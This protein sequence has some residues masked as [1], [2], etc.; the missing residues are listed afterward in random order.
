MTMAYSFVVYTGNGV[1]QQYAVTFPFLERSHVAVTVNGVQSTAFTWVSDS[2]IR[3]NVA[4][5][6]GSTIR[7]SRNSNRQARLS[8]FQDAQ[9]LTEA[10]LDFDSRQNFYVAQEAFD[11]FS[12]SVGGGDMLRS[13]NLSDVFNSAAALQNIG[14]VNRNGDSM[15]GPLFLPGF[16]TAAQ[17][18]ATKGYVDYIVGTISLPALTLT[19][20][21]IINALGYTPVNKN[22]DTFTGPM[23]VSADPTA[24]LG[25]ATKQYVDNYVIAATGT[26]EW[27][28]RMPVSTATAS[29][30]LNKTVAPTSNAAGAANL[31]TNRN[32]GQAMANFAIGYKVSA[33]TTANSDIGLTSYVHATS[34]NGGGIIGVNTVAAGPRTDT[35]PRRLLGLDVRVAERAVDQGIQRDRNAS[36]KISIAAQFGPDNSIDFGDGSPVGFNAS[37]GIVLQPSNDKAIKTWVPLFFEQDCTAPLGVQALHRGGSTAANAPLSALE[38]RDYF[39]NGLDFRN[40]TFTDPDVTAIW[41][42]QGQAMHFS[43]FSRIYCDPTGNLTFFDG[44]SGTLSLADILAQAGAGATNLLPLNNNWTGRN[45]FVKQSV[46]GF[47]A[48]QCISYNNGAVGNGAITLDTGFNTALD[49]RKSTNA[50]AESGYL[51]GVA[52]AYIQH[53]VTGQS[54]S[55]TVNSGIRV[56][57]QTTQTR[58]GAFTNDVV[59]GYFGLYNGGNESG[60]FGLHVDAYHAAGGANATTYGASVEMMRS[61]AAGFTVG[62]HART[63]GNGYQ[64]ND[65]GVLV[66]PGAGAAGNAYFYKAFS[67]GSANTGYLLCQYGLDLRY[68]T[69]DIAAISVPSNKYITWDDGGAIKMRFN[70]GTGRVEWLNGAVGRFGFN[71]TNGTIYAFDG[72]NGTFGSYYVDPAGVQD[73]IMSVRSGG[74]TDAPANWSTIANWLAIRIDGFRYKI[75][76]YQ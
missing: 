59:G 49:V 14:G 7:V 68:A 51:G 55:A 12:S 16:P 61:S 47:P 50:A 8:D 19:G 15:L 17:E 53:N 24:P 28:F 75:P 63:I 66:G 52:G 73:S 13:N 34:T 72:V 71:M 4:P 10:S 22:G 20:S 37:F 76:L 65:Y 18:A 9:S 1:T 62:Y 29:A 41:L 2:L 26:G 67:A 46:T 36:N 42:A 32:G 38:F 6:N 69:C 39:V 58:A 31:F 35:G 25:V 33:T 23:L 48:V 11:G 21:M 70:G 5:A 45:S 57:M 64:N 40:A 74:R 44:I 30:L 54:A 56:Q 27:V 60:G 43:P 3:F